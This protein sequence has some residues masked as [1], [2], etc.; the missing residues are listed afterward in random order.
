M[1]TI[2]INFKNKYKK[3][4]LLEK[5]MEGNWVKIIRISKSRIFVL[6]DKRSAIKEIFNK[7]I[8]FDK[9]N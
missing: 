5:P 6:K 4:N 1:K 7:S 3:Q 8:D 2:K 9:C